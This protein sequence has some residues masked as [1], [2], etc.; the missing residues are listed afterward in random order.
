MEGHDN[1]GAG[2][3]EVDDDYVQDHLESHAVPLSNDELIELDKASQEAE[4]EKDEEEEPMR[5]LD[6]KSLE[7]VLVVLKKLWKP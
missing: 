3:D 2:F 7:N 5:G 4:K 6:I 1:G